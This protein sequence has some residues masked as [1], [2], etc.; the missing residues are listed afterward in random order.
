MKNSLALIISLLLLA[1]TQVQAQDAKAEPSTPASSA[2]QN[3]DGNYKAQFGVSA[4][5]RTFSVAAEVVL[6]GTE[7]TWRTSMTG[8]NCLNQIAPV[9]VTSS[10]D[11]ELKFV[12][13]YSKTLSGCPDFNVS[14][15]RVD[16]KTF[17]GSGT[18]SSGMT[19]SDIKMIKQ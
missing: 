3:V 7:G 17:A 10:T 12:A 2:A 1:A 5:G 18:T 4:Y 6:K 16:D 14:L 19:I 11:S 8:N 15:K 13:A 9:T